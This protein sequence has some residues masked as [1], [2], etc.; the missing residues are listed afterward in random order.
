M[1]RC[2]FKFTEK[3]ITCKVLCI[4]LTI[5]L[6]LLQLFFYDPDEATTIRTRQHTEFDPDIVRCLTDMLR[7]INS[8]IMLHK[9]ASEALRENAA[10]TDDSRVTDPTLLW[11]RYANDIYDDLPHRLRSMTDVPDDIINPNLDYSLY[12]LNEVLSDLGKR[13]EDYNMPLFTYDWGRSTGNPLIANEMTYDFNEETT[14]RNERYTQLNAD[15][16]HCFDTI[17]AGV[18]DHP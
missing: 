16:K 9:T 1:D 7:N 3:Y 8:F 4:P 12:L 11:N 15:Q 17:V 5:L 18:R 13:L 10:T 14:L 2:V 6:A